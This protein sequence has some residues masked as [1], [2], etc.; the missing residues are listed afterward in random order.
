[1]P[2]GPKNVPPAHR[3]VPPIVII[4]DNYVVPEDACVAR[5]FGVLWP[6]LWFPR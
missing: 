1:V 5:V 4:A 6:P 3:M 2:G